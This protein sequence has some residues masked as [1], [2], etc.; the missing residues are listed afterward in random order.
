LPYRYNGDAIPPFK[1]LVLTPHQ[2][3]ANFTIN[4]ENKVV[5]GNHTIGSLTAL[6]A[7]PDRA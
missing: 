3:L 5:A 1:V 2:L 6:M 7:S 4:M